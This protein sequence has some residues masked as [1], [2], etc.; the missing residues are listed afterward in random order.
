MT[1]KHHQRELIATD[2]PGPKYKFDSEKN[3][4]NKLSAPKYS[5]SMGQVNAIKPGSPVKRL[6]TIY[7]V[8]HLIS[9]TTDIYFQ[10]IENLG[11]Q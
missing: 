5:F 10:A 11:S 8:L 9:M 6:V 4:S 2:S 1:D 7:R 3:N